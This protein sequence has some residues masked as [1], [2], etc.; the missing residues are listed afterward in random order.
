MEVG[1]WEVEIGM[2]LEIGSWKVEIGN[3]NFRAWNLEF[4]RAERGAAVRRD[5]GVRQHSCVGYYPEVCLACEVI[6]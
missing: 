6:V 4:G 3:W 1:N 2:K 5:G